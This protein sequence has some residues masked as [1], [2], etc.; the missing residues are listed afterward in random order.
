MEEEWGLSELLPVGW[1]P[2]AKQFP[3]A[4]KIKK[5]KKEISISS[6]AVPSTRAG[7]LEGHSGTGL[8]A[9]LNF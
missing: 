9:S 4:K 5:K 6:G 8:P 3:K 2:W 7:H 1:G